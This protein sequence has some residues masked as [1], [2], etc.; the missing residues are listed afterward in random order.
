MKQIFNF[1]K[2]TIPKNNIVYKFE[3]ETVPVSTVKEQNTQ[4]LPLSKNKIKIKSKKKA[5]NR[6]I[7]GNI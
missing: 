4:P 1:A 3:G 2:I 6:D 7:L 5:R